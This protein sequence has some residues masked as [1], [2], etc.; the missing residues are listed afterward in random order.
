MPVLLQKG[1]RE[2]AIHALINVW[3][4]DPSRRC[5]NC[6]EDY[7]P[8][9]YCCDQPF[10]A[11]NSQILQQFSREL[12]IRRED[13]LNK[14]GSNKEKNLRV[15]VSLPVALH[16]FLEQAMKSQYGEKLFT[17]EYPPSWFA[18]KFYKYFAVPQEV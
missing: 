6:G 14:Y 2:D 17:K 1:S 7:M 9:G 18:K 4:K 11:T 16:A 3:L 10:I 15:V 5:G 12:H 8:G 13:Q